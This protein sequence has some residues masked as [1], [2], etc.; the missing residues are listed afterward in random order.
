MSTKPAISSTLDSFLDVV[1]SPFNVAVKGKSY[2]Y[3]DYLSLPPG[4]RVND[5]ADVVDVHFTELVLEWLGFHKSAAHYKYNTTTPKS[6]VESQRP[7]FVA[8]GPIGTAFIWEDKNTTEEFDEVFSAKLGQYTAGTTGYAVWSNAK[9]IIGFRFDAKGHSEPLVDMDI[10]L[11]VECLD[12]G[13]EKHQAQLNAQISALELF[14]ILFSRERFAAFDSLLNKICVDENTY[15]AQAKPLTSTD[16]QTQFINGARQVLDHLRLSALQSIERALRHLEEIPN[17]ELSLR[18]EWVKSKTLFEKQLSSALTEGKKQSLKTVIENMELKLGVMGDNEVSVEYLLKLCQE[19]SAKLPSTDRSSIQLW[20]KNAKSINGALRKLR[21]E[22]SETRRIVDAFQVW[23][24]RQLI[25]NLASPSIFAEQV[26]Y[27]IFVRLLLARIL[28]DKG[29]LG[30]RIASDGGVT[31]WRQIVDRYLGA[32]NSTIHADSFLSLLSE[33]LSRYYRHFF[34]Q[35]VFDWFRPDDYF[36]VEALEFLS[37]YNFKA[38]ESDLLGFT[39]EE[40]VDRVARNKKGHFL[41]RPEVVD[42]ML[43]SS[44]YQ[45]NATLGRR[46]LDPSCGSGS[47]IVHALRRYREALIA[48]VG[49]KNNLSKEEV[50]G[51]EASRLEVAQNMVGAAVDLFY[52]MDIDPFPCYLAELNMLIQLLED[53]HFLWQKK[54]GSTIERFHIY[55][56]DSLALPESVLSSTMVRVLW[57]R[58]SLPQAAPQQYSVTSS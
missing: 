10:K 4:V 21:L 31:A 2:K 39:Y 6:K 57:A 51:Q 7:D 43:N 9:R 49:K 27:V 35:P 58:P 30:Q 20:V 12:S 14:F 42:Y 45:G 56:T 53:L 25:A 52:G 23:G 50:L 13:D 22:S 5:E 54:L 41:T 16:D 47:F 24:E 18:Q 29:L 15:L 36:L 33:S 28:E 40:Y 11:L 32:G 44:G 3:I 46:F 48:A 8:L 19:K 26:A 37:R 1:I 38:V 34:Q 17:R 55:I